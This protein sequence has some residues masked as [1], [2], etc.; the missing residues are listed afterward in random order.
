M[1]KLAA[2]SYFETY[3]EYVFG[4]LGRLATYIRLYRRLH[5][6]KADR[7]KEMNIA[8]AFFSTTIDALFSAIVLWVDKLFGDRSER[9]FLN[10]LMFV[11][12]NRKIFDI[13]QLQRRKNYPDNHWMLQNREPVTLAR[14]KNDRQRIVAFTPLTS[15]KLRRDKFYAHFDKQYFFDRSKLD[16]DAPLTWRDLEDVVKLGKDILNSYSADYDG[17]LHAVEPINAGDV[18]HLLNYLHRQLQNN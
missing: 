8:P 10:L 9:G 7:S 5:E 17:K 14:I 6:R 4:E 11:E 12:Q 1:N 15:F 18:D 3:R 13:K 2:E 16:A